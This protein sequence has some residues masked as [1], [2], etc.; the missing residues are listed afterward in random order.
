V[1]PWKR[2]LSLIL[3]KI[4]AYHTEKNCDPFRDDGLKLLQGGASDTRVVVH[5][6]MTMAVYPFWGFV[7]DITGRLLKLQGSATICPDT[8]RIKEQLVSAR[9]CYQGA[10]RVSA[11]PSVDW[12]VLL[13]TSGKVCTSMAP[14]MVVT[15]ERLAVVG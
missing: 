9:D 5:W 14:K 11:L 12:Q 1:A 13:D 4:W 15:D 10:Q 2:T 8:A 3:V 6:G 7:A